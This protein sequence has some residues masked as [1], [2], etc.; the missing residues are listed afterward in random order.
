MS[1]KKEKNIF[2]GLCVGVVISFLLCGYSL[3]TC[4]AFDDTTGLGSH[5]LEISYLFLHLVLCGI[6]FY[7][8]FRAMKFGSFFI[9]NVTYDENGDPYKSKRITFIV[10][11]SIFVI[12]F[13]YSIIQCFTMTLP[14]AVELGK[15][16]WHDIMNAT[17]LASII[18]ATFILYPLYVPY[19]RN[20]KKFE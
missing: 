4:F 11:D 8:S 18:F 12:I 7:F 9:K 5:I 20:N 16:V 17:F 3:I 19:D 10:L 2:L 13:V 14:L 15:I 1:M 6:L